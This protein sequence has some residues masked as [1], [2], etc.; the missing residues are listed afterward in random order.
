[1]YQKKKKALPKKL[2]SRLRKLRKTYQDIW[3]PE[4]QDRYLTPQPETPLPEAEMEPM[5]HLGCTNG[6]Y[7]NDLVTASL[8][9]PGNLASDVLQSNQLYQQILN[10]FGQE[11]NDFLTANLPPE[12]AQELIGSRSF[13]P[14][15]I[16]PNEANEVLSTVFN[17]ASIDTATNYLECQPTSDPNVSI[18]ATATQGI[19]GGHA[20][21]LS[22][23]GSVSLDGYNS[24][25]GQ[26]FL[27]T[28]GIRCG[29]V[30]ESEFIPCSEALRD[31][32]VPI[33]NPNPT[34]QFFGFQS[35]TTPSPSYT[36]DQS[37]TYGTIVT[38]SWQT[39]FQNNVYLSSNTELF[40]STYSEGYSSVSLSQEGLLWTLWPLTKNQNR[41]TNPSTYFN[42]FTF[43]TATQSKF[44]IGQL[45][46]F[47]NNQ[48]IGCTPFGSIFPS[49]TSFSSGTSTRT[50]STNTVALPVPGGSSDEVIINNPSFSRSEISLQSSTRQGLPQFIGI[51]PGI[52]NFNNT[53]IT[54]T[55]QMVALV[56]VKVTEQV[57]RIPNPSSGVS[58]EEA[59]IYVGYDGWSVVRTTMNP[60]SPMAAQ[61]Y[62]TPQSVTG[63]VVGEN[64][65][66]IFPPNFPQTILFKNIQRSA[67]TNTETGL[68]S[69][70]PF[71]PSGSK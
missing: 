63:S 69:G 26:N 58:S 39:P 1:M 57:A 36:Q 11:P 46:Y 24:S 51:I 37:T 53:L 50:V 64:Y 23:P 30:S 34:S 40:N 29:Q 41:S 20:L 59:F 48:Q 25:Q 22:Q 27:N 62:V 45:A 55:Q 15:I 43:G 44:A 70:T 14:G 18:C 19:A 33:I 4:F 71:A 47:S 61:T 54:T 3:E 32:G 60:I 35:N 8:V 16:Q 12:F 5:V 6:T 65:Q 31:S 49:S 52:Q 42:H 2:L 9:V 7:I 66:I 13:V 56:V 38:S 10:T 21:Y 67:P 28:I 68:F 17:T